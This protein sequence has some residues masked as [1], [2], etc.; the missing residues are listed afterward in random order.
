MRREHPF[1]LIKDKMEFAFEAKQGDGRSMDS[2]LTA[3]SHRLCVSDLSS[4][5]FISFVCKMGI[6]VLTSES[7]SEDNPKVNKAVPG[8]CYVL[9]EVYLRTFSVVSCRRL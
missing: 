3:Y 5:S 6:T 4:L 8:K 7:I 1:E 9:H 2:D